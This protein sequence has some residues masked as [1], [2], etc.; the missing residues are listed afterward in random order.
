MGN[1]WVEIDTGKCVKEIVSMPDEKDREC[2]FRTTN[3]DTWSW[4]LQIHVICK[5]WGEVAHS[6]FL[7]EPLLLDYFHTDFLFAASVYDN[8]T[9]L[10]I[11]PWSTVTWK[12]Q[13]TDSSAWQTQTLR[14]AMGFDRA[15]QTSAY[16]TGSS[17]YII[18]L[19]HNWIM[20]GKNE[21]CDKIINSFKK[22][23]IECLTFRK[24]ILLL[25]TMNRPGRISLSQ[26][27]FDIKWY[28]FMDNCGHLA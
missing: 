26:S 12:L 10:L 5:L 14:P 28:V 25:N 7:T 3:N 15:T 4:S 16:Y 17:L 20:R 24:T 2:F 23:V 13:S 18:H 21:I 1:K 8:G 6:N 19:L 27:C 11:V 9:R 22:S